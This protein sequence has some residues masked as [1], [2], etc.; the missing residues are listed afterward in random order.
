M[1]IDSLPGSLLEALDYMEKSQVAKDALGEH[2]FNE[3]I[4]AKKIEWDSFRI[5][6]TPWELER[7]L[8]KY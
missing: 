3:F 5:V 7:Y 8:D 2:I 6:V 1:R 4:N